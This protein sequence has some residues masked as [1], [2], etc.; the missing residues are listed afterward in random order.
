MK[1]ILAAARKAVVRERLDLI[2]GIGLAP[3]IMSIDSIALANAFEYAMA[4]LPLG[5]GTPP[6][7]ASGQPQPDMTRGAAR[8]GPDESVL[9]V[10]VGAARTILN[11]MSATGLVFTRDVEV[12]GNSAT[13]AIARGMGIEFQEAERRKQGGDAAAR[14]FVASM[15][16]I[17]SRELRSTCSYVSSK[18]NTNVGKIYLSGG[19]ALCQ[20]VRETLASEMGIEVSFW[21]PLRG[22]APGAGVATGEPGSK[23]ALLAVAAGLA[24]TD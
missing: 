14:E 2:N 3:R 6:P 19:G 9:V 17:L 16:M 18:M 13:L 11:V 15:V 21:N 4:G 24:L 20:G 23:E 8:S 12:G 5:G 22:I 1:V 10:H 7:G